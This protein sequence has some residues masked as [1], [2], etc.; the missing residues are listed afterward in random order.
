MAKLK[1]SIC[2]AQRFFGCAPCILYAERV[3]KEKGHNATDWIFYGAIM[4]G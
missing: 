4:R 3:E 1:N 2:K